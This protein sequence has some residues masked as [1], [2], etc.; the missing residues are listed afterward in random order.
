M[1]INREVPAKSTFCGGVAAES[2][3]SKTA[4]SAASA[5]F[6]KKSACP[7]ATAVSGTRKSRNC[8]GPALAMSAEPPT[9]SS[10]PAVAVLPEW[11]LGY[12]PPKA[13][14]AGEGHERRV[15]EHVE[16][17]CEHALRHG[18][19]VLGVGFQDE[20]LS[21]AQRLEVPAGRVGH[22]Q[23]QSGTAWALTVI[24]VVSTASLNGELPP[25]ADA[26]T[27]LVP[28]A[29]PS[30]LIPGAKRQARIDRAEEPR[31]GTKRM[32]S[33]GP[34]PKTT[35][36]VTDT[37]ANEVQ[38]A[39]PSVEYCQSPWS[40]L[41]P[42]TAIPCGSP[43]FGSVIAVP[44]MSA[45]NVPGLFASRTSARIGDSVGLPVVCKTGAAL[46]GRRR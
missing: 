46:S 34:T 8:P 28:S 23:L 15:K 4:W 5:W 37:P 11:P 43:G 31:A 13:D 20:R 24:A 45:I 7:A 9:S 38:V 17:R 41:A 19:H 30:D 14:R 6:A 2:P 35:A 36:D 33:R 18:A 40:L 25:P 42:M 10:K 29:W 39:P 32:R 16:I 44:T 21:D 27:P 22:A 1:T 3:Y 26:S 12:C